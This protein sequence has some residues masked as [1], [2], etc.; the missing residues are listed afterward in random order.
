MFTP[1]DEAA[2]A[3]WLDDAVARRHVCSHTGAPREL[4]SV[5]VLELEGASIAEQ[6]R[7]FST[8]D[9]LLAAHG[10]ALGNA[11]WMRADA[12][13]VELFME[14]WWSPWFEWPLRFMGIG[15]T[16]V[17]CGAGENCL[18]DAEMHAA[19]VAAVAK[20]GNDIETQKAI[21]TRNLRANVKKV[22]AAVL[23]A[24]GH[25]AMQR[26]AGEGAAA[27]SGGPGV[28]D[29]APDTCD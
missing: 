28:P 23:A 13:V 17:P 6:V 7:A 2:A 14:G 29:P 1:A 10:N 5:R 19:R 22:A 27:G 16:Y 21:K 20:L 18:P 15:Y 8:T 24:V 9:V 11:V 4:V 26:L 25:V 12:A 3:A